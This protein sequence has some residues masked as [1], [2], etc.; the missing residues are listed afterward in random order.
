MNDFELLVDLH[1][2]GARQGPGGKEQT[3]LA[4]HLAGLDKKPDLAIADIGCGTGA[5]TIV[6]AEELN[7]HITAI[8]F[9]P[10]FLERLDQQAAKAKL[11]HKITTQAQAM[12]GLNIPDS[13]LDVIWS[14]GA[15]YNIGFEKGVRSWRN[16]LK[17]DGVLAVSEL[18]WLTDK[19]PQELQDHWDHEYP[20]V[21]T[22]GRKISIL[23]KQGFSVIG[24]FPLPMECWLDN[25][26]RPMQ[27]RFSEFLKRHQDNPKAT[28]IIEAEKR[29]IALYETY[30]DYVSYG[31]YIARKTS[32]EA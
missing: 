23:E 27:A 16:W 5:S 7:G 13:S 28:A 31:F 4:I 2:S 18:T 30:S 11:A 17:P 9:L 1:K 25:Y 8:D 19:R 26:Y 20:E 22:A 29:E 10:A 15:I 32:A 14:E 3:R 21:D 12:E 6:L 24:Y